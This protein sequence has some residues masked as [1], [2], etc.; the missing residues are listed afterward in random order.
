[1]MIRNALASV[2]VAS[3]LA[4]CATPTVPLHD[5]TPSRPGFDGAIGSAGEVEGSESGT[6]ASADADST[7][8]SN[9]TLGSGS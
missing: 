7:G 1:M 4:G 5:G 8:R 2:A 9:Y 3:L 6:S